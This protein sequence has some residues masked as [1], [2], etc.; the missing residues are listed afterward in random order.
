MTSETNR[1][2]RDAGTGS[3]IPPRLG[4]SKYWAVQVRDLNGRQVR[5]SRFPHTGKKIIGALRNPDAD[6]KLPE[7]WTNI[8]AAKEMAKAWA[9]EVGDGN[10][11][12]G[13]DPSQLHYGDLRAMYLTDYAEQEMSSLRTN[14]EGVVYVDSLTHLDKFFG[15][16]KAGD[17]G[18]KVNHIE[19]R[20]DAFKAARKE[21]GAAN[22]TINRALS[23]L[24]RMFSLAQ[25]KHKIQSVPFIKMLPEPT[26]PRQGFLTVTEY[27]RLYAALG[28]E[29]KN[30]A[31]G[32]VS[33]PYAYIQPLLQTGFFTGM[34][35]GE[36]MNLQWSNVD[37]AQEIITLRPD[38]T[39]TENGRIIP[40]IDGLPKLFEDLRR[41]HPKAGENDK[42]FTNNG[43][44]IRSFIKAWRNACVQAAIPT[45]LKGQVVISHFEGSKYVG[46]VFHDLRRT[47]IS[48]M[49]DAEVDPLYAMAISGH[50]TDSV[51]KRYSI[52]R[53]KPLQDAGRKMAAKLREK[54]QDAEAAAPVPKMQVVK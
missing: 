8:S 31:T 13:N 48:N 45:K 37:V 26:Q 16:E 30:Q 19:S 25:E 22:G 9:R 6:P 3:L 51:Y 12:V 18:I 41:A 39:K 54:R 24:T 38:Q 49:N 4:I 36:I 29:V 47:F 43:A 2:K 33:T 15:Y 14:S 50:Q 34:R 35:L 7:S 23:A 44:P 32:K 5:R 27:D 21:A 20:I 46:F 17:K 42:V 10:V 52:I 28:K 40:M 1:E 11:S 53:P